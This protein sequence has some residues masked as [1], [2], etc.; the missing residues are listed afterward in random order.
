MGFQ[1]SNRF[2]SQTISNQNQ[3]VTLQIWS[4]TSESKITIKNT[5]SFICQN[6]L[7]FESFHRVQIIESF[8]EYL[9]QSFISINRIKTDLKMSYSIRNKRQDIISTLGSNRII[10]QV[11]LDCLIII[12][13][14]WQEIFYSIEAE[15]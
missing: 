7:N 1:K 3:R 8:S 5:I 11:N 6:K 4:K 15:T 10:G 14:N 13:L 2:F 12:Q 9:S